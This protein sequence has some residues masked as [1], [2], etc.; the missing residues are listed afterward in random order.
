MLQERVAKLLKR[1]EE[2]ESLLGSP[3]VLSDQKQFK[4]LAQEH[5]YLTEI[6]E[7]WQKLKK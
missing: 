7:I 6:K 4:A 1:A 3:E 5:A 2:V